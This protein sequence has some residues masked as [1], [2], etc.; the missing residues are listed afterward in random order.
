[1]ALDAATTCSRMLSGGPG[2]DAKVYNSVHCKNYFYN[3]LK[4]T[5][6]ADIKRQL[7]QIKIKYEHKL[8]SCDFSKRKLYCHVKEN[9]L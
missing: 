5:Q 1:M 4:N 3:T 2:I 6:I 9:H 8:N 7:L